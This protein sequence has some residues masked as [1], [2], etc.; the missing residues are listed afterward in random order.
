[1]LKIAII[2]K[3]DITIKIENNSI[4]F[5]EQTIP[6]RLMDIL[7]LNHRTN[8]STSDILKLTKQNISILILSY[9]NTHSAIVNSANTKN[10]DLKLSQYNSLSQKI[11][12][13]KY[14]IREKLKSHQEHLKILD[15]N[16][17]I[18]EK[19]KLLDD[20]ENIDNIMGIEGS[21]AREYFKYFFEQFPRELHNSKRTKNPPKDP[22][23]A[24][25]SF[26]YSMYYNI[27]SIRLMSYG[28]EPGIGY[29]HMAFRS[30]NALAS[31]MME[32]F[33]SQINHA[34]IL[35]FKNKLLSIEDFSKKEGVYLKYEG[36]KKIYKEFVNLVNVLNPQ[37]DTHIATIKRM[38]NETNAHS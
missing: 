33:R 15:I 4:K 17:D 12:F 28:F 29:L 20:A 14:F 38:I 2:D 27:I 24:V 8:I 3:K 31:D 22:V 16:V 32:L 30:H 9:N 36:R 6:F 13:A 19:L 7:I 5:K 25:L 10:G 23:N 35:L 11:I 37:L 1:M 21:F 26:W 34:V 18:D